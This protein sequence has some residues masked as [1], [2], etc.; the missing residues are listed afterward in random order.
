[1]MT[2]KDRAAI[3]AEAPVA[4]SPRAASRASRRGTWLGR[5]F[6]NMLTDCFPVW[7]DTP[8]YERHH[9]LPRPAR[10]KGDALAYRTQTALA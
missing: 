4:S 1:M 6:G 8:P 10:R 2:E 5:V 3:R 7:A 9:S